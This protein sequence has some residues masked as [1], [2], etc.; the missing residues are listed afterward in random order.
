MKAL[1]FIS[2]PGIYIEI[3]QTA[4]RALDGDDGLELSLDRQESGRL[5]PECVERL[6]E[7]LRVFVRKRSWQ[8][9]LRAICA[10][11][12]RGVSLRRISL[13]QCS[14]DELERLLVLQIEREFPLGPEELA[15]GYRPLTEVLTRRNGAPGTQ[16]VLVAAVKRDV[17][18][19][20]SQILR[21]CG[22]TPV[23]TLGA[24]AR[25]ALCSGPPDAFAVLEIGVG[26]SELISFEHGAPAAIRAL[27]WGVRELAGYS[28]AEGQDNGE[29]AQSIQP[30]WIGQKLY[31]ATGDGAEITPQFADVIAQGA[32]WERLETPSGEG[33]SSA[34]LG[35]KRCF[36][37]NGSAP[38]LL[39]QLAAS[40]E[41]EQT[42]T[43][44]AWKWAAAA[45]LLA[46]VSFAL[47]YA[48]VLT[49]KPRLVRKIAEVN[50]YRAK[51]PNLERELSFLQYLQTNQPA[52]FDPLVAMANA[53]PSGTRIDALSMTRRGDVS[54]RAT[55]RDPQQVMQ[56]RSRL[57]ESSAFSSLV[58]E[59][60]NPSSDRQKVTVRIA[61][62][63]QAVGDRK[64]APTTPARDAKATNA[65]SAKPEP[66]SPTPGATQ[67]PPSLEAVP[68][69]ATRG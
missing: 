56:F 11:G 10:I 38:S 3:G 8:P 31:V 36:E 49:H 60:Q 44:S 4:L 26:H 69:T 61:G 21:A 65:P 45:I 67:T 57:I 29:L 1:P 39:L 53:A 32:R 51:L 42:W 7:S 35:L 24:L 9:R 55:M 54:I 59:E 30:K 13:P 33:R 23:F 50:A 14:K 6:T 17:V 5:M 43:P 40:R 63:W 68:A 34:I 47:R 37:E 58:I 12:A 28:A 52:Y 20:Y 46:L 48:E 15:W 66:E 25:S 27:P 64:P 62:Q 41:V 2:S 22:L 16:E 18:E 19:E